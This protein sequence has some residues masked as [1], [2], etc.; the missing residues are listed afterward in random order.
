MAK[1]IL[2][3]SVNQWQK[4]CIRPSK[5]KTDEN[6]IK[7]IFNKVRLNGDDALIYY[8]RHFDKVNLRGLLLHR[9][10][11]QKASKKISPQLKTA[12]KRAYDNIHRFHA[13]TFNRKK[14]KRV[15]GADGVKA[16]R[17][18]VPISKAGLYIPGGHAPLFSTVLMLC[19]PARLAGCEELVICT[20]PSKEG[21]IH[22]AMAYALELCGVEKVFLCGGAQAIAAMAYGTQSVPKVYKIFGPGNAWV[23]AAKMYALQQ[24]LVAI[25]MPAG[26][27]EVLVIADEYAKPDWVSADLLSQ[28]EHGPD[29]QAILLTTSENFAKSVQKAAR[30]Q[31]KSLPGNS[32]AHLSWK[33]SVLA[34]VRSTEE[35]IRL[36]NLY[37]PEHLIIQSRD[38][39]SLRKKVMNAG[40]VFLGPWSTEPLGDYITGPNH[41][42]PTAGHAMAWSGISV[43]SFMKSITF[44]EVTS[45]GIQ[46]L[47]THAVEM[48]LAEG[49]PAHAQA[50][51]IR[52]IPKNKS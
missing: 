44:Q 25:D 31:L 43:E 18:S 36:S 32:F 47:G 23:T 15:V 34:V 21:G 6:L 2:Y 35:C 29:S 19:I 3:P 7:N 11:I 42:L 5:N 24:G 27:S 13:Q 51:K 28:C 48:A 12:I 30:E 41:T 16:W 9:N 22:P 20:P 26:P 46:R 50:I 49:L 14:S 45:R 39:E 52:L 4:V 37:A 33:N 8:T 1:V 10:E 17:E 40:S 38:A